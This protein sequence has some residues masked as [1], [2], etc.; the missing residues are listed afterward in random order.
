MNES[1]L[2]RIL[3]DHKRQTRSLALILYLSM[4]VSLGTF[5][6]FHKTAV[7]KVYTKKVLDCPCSY[8]GAKPVAHTHND[9]C[10]EGDTLV[11]KLTELEAHTHSD[12]CYTE[13]QVLS[14]GLEESPGHQH[15]DECYDADAA[16]ICTIP[17][18]EGAHTHTA[19]CY[20]TVRELICDKP[21]LPL[22]VHD[23]DCFYTE[24]ITIDETEQT[25]EPEQ[26]N[27]PKEEEQTLPEMP[28]GDPN[29]DLESAA[30]WERDFD[31][32]EL[33]GN[34][35]ADLILVAATQQGHGESSNNFKAV[36]N[37]AGDAWVKH[38]YTRYGAWYGN[39]YGEW[40]AMFVSFCLR[41]AGIPDK[42]IPNKSTAAAMGESFRNHELFAGRN[43]VPAVGDLIF[44]DTDDTEGIDLMGIVYYVDEENGTINTVE[45]DRTDEV[46]TFGYHLDD[47]EIAGYGILLQN[48]DYVYDETEEDETGVLIVTTEDKDENEEF[49]ATTKVKNEETNENEERQNTKKETMPAQSWERTAGGI[50]VVVEAPEGAFPENT[51]IAV[52]PVNGNSL[53]D[54]VSDAV[55]GEVLEVQAV[56]ITFFNAEGR[57]IEP[58]TAIRVTMIPAETENAEE[59]ANVVH[60]DVGQQTAELIAQAEGTETDNSE[61]VFDAEAFT[62]YAIVYTVHFEYEVDGETFTSASMPGAEYTSLAEVIRGLGIVSKEEI[63]TFVSRIATVA[64]TNEDVAK[65]ENT[66]EGL[67]VRVLKDG[68]AQIVITMQDG[69]AFRVDVVADGETAT[70]N[71]TATVSTVGDLYLPAEAKVEAKV[72]NETQSENAIA[73]VQAVEEP[74]D[75]N[76]AAETA[77][78]VFDISLENVEADQYDGFQVEVT[79]PDNVVGRD[80]RL[81]HIHDGETSEIELNTVSR[82]ADDTG[83]EV[84]SGFTFETKDFSEFVLRY[85]V[86]FTYEGR[87]WSFPGEGSYRLADILAVLG[88]EGSIDDASVTLIEGEDHAGALYLTQNDGEYYIN[89]DIAFTDIYELRVQIGEKIYIITVTDEQEREVSLRE[90]LQFVNIKIDGT[91]VVDDTWEVNEGQQY[92]ITL[93]FEET[94]S[95][96]QLNTSGE[97]S[98]QL[99]EGIIIP[100]TLNADLP[101]KHNG[102]PLR[103]NKFSVSTDGKITLELTEE[104]KQHI[105]DSGDSKF[106]INII[107]QFDGKTTVFEFNDDIIKEVEVTPKHNAKVEKTSTYDPQSGKIHY[108]V[109]VIAEGS[110][111]NVKVGDTVTGN[112]AQNISNF[113]VSKEATSQ[114][115]GNGAKSYELIFDTLTNEMVTIEYD[116]PID[117]SQFSGDIRTQTIGNN[118]EV[119]GDDDDNPN[120]NKTSTSNTISASSFNKRGTTEEEAFTGVDGKTYKR[121]KW[122]VEANDQRIMQL[123]FIEDHIAENSKDRMKYDWDKGIDVVVTKEDGTTSTIHLTKEEV[124]GTDYSWRF[125]TSSYGKASFKA[126]YYTIVEISGLVDDILVTNEAES[127]QGGSGSSVN[128]GPNEEDKLQ[129]EKKAIDVN[130]E[131]ITWKITINVPAD[132]YESLK[133]VEELPHSNGN[134]TYYD[135]LVVPDDNDWSSCVSGLLEGE[136]MELVESDSTQATFVFYKSAGETDENTGLNPT[137]DGKNR[138]V[139]ITLKTKNNKE[140]LEESITVKWRKDHEN[141]AKVTANN[142]EKTAKDTAYPP[143]KHIIKVTESSD[144]KTVNG[145]E[146]PRYHFTA[147]LEG[148]DQDSLTL[149]ET[150]DTSIFMIDDEKGVHIYAGNSAYWVG[151]NERTADSVQATYT[152]AV[153]T[154]NSLEKKDGKRFN[155]YK[156]DYYLVV[157]DEEALKNLYVKADAA[158]NHRETFQNTI[159]WGA[160]EGNS[161]FDYSYPSVTKSAALN[162]ETGIVY[163]T[164]VINPEKIKLLNGADEERIKLED[165]F[166]N[167]AVKF[168]TINIVSEPDRGQI[169]Y[170]YSG[171]TGTFWIPDETKVIITYQ[172][173]VV[174]DDHVSYYNKAVMKG[175]FSEQNGE[176]TADADGSG[177][178]NTYRI[179][180]FKYGKTNMATGLDGAEFTLVDQSG[181]PYRYPAGTEKAGQ[182]IKF[183]T[184][185]QTIDGEQ[186]HGYADIFLSEQGDGI[187]LRPGQRYYLKETKAPDGYKVADFLYS[188]TISPH[189]NYDNYEFYLDDVLKARDE[190]VE[191]SIVIR[192]S[193]SGTNTGLTDVQRKAITFTITKENDSSFAPV[194]LTYDQFIDDMYVL[195]GLKDGTYIVTETNNSIPGYTYNATTYTLDGG[196]VTPS[197][198]VSV[199]ISNADTHTVMITNEYANTDASIRIKK[200]DADNNSYSLYG[201]EFKLQKKNE[202]GNYED[203]ETEILENSIVRIDYKNMDT[204]VTLVGLEGGD[205][206]LVEIKAPDGYHGLEKPIRF[207]I[208]A[209]GVATDGVTYD[210][211]AVSGDPVSSEHLVSY[212]SNNKMLTVGNKIWHTYTIAK[213]QKGDSEKVLEGAKFTVYKVTNVGSQVQNGRIVADLDTL[214]VIKTY[215][216][217]ADGQLRICWEDNCYEEEQMYVVVETGAPAGY[218]LPELKDRPAYLFHF[219]GTG[220]GIDLKQKSGYAFVEDDLKTTVLA[221]AKSW[222]NLD[223]QDINSSAPVDQ[224]TFK[225]KQTVTVNGET[226]ENYYPDEET[227]YSVRKVNGNWTNTLINNLPKYFVEDGTEYAYIY[228]VEEQE[229]EGFVTRYSDPEDYLENNAVV[230]SKITITNE[231]ESVSISAKKVWAEG[232]PEEKKLAQN[233]SFELERR[234][235]TDTDAAWEKVPN[236]RKNITAWDGTGFAPVND[237]WKVE[238][239]RLS[240]EY[241]YRAVE[242]IQGANSDRFD[243]DYSKDEDGNIIVTNT[244]KST[245]ISAKKVW[246]DNTPDAKKSFDLKFQLQKKAKDA[247]E[248]VDFEDY[249]Q[250][251][252]ITTYSTDLHSYVPIVNGTKTENQKWIAT[253]NNWEA[254]WKDL[255]SEYIY[256]VKEILPV[257]QTDKFEIT[258]SENNKEGIERGEITVTNTYNKTFVEVEK[259][260]KDAETSHPAI[261]LELRRFSDTHPVEKHKEGYIPENQTHYTFSDLEVNDEEGNPWKYYVIESWFNNMGAYDISC[262]VTA[263]NAITSGKILITNTKKNEDE[264]AVKKLWLDKDG[265]PID[266]PDDNQSIDIQL[267][268]RQGVIKPGGVPVTL[269]VSNDLQY[270]IT[271]K[272]NSILVF[273][274]KNY[275]NGCDSNIE[276]F[277]FID[278]S[279]DSETNAS[280]DYYTYQIGTESVTVSFSGNSS[281]S[282]EFVSFEQDMEFGPAENVGSP[283]ELS[284]ANNWAYKWTDLTPAQN[285]IYFVEEITSVEGF[286]QE[287]ENN[288]G[289]RTGIIYVKNIKEENDTGALKFTKQ[290]TVNGNTPDH[291]TKQL[292]DGDYTFTITGP[293]TGAI[294]TINQ[295]VVIKVED[296]TAAQYKIDTEFVPLPPDGYV[297]ISDLPEGD[298]VI[299]ETEK[300]N[301]TLVSIERGDMKNDGTY[302]NGSPV[303]LADSRV[304]VHVTA[305]DIQAV[306]PDAKATFTNNLIEVS[307]LEGTKKWSITGTE[308]PTDPQLKLIRTANG[309]TTEVTVPEGQPVWTGENEN[310]TFKYTDLPKYNQQGY[311]YTYNVSEASFTIRRGDNEFHYRV[312]RDESG[313]YN[314]T[315][316]KQNAPKFTVTQTENAIINIEL[317]DFE[318]SKIWKNAS[319]GEA[320]WQ[321]N[322]AI[323]VTVSRK[324]EQSS[325]E[326][327]ETVGTYTILKTESGFTITKQTAQETTP[328]LVEMAG[329][330]EKTYTFQIQNLPKTGTIEGVTGEYT[331]SVTESALSGYN[332]RYETPDA[333]QP[334]KTITTPG[335]AGNGGWIINTPVGGYELPE[336]GGIGTTLFTALGGLMTVTAGAILTMRRGKRKIAEG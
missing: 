173:R 113:T 180:L 326:K 242:I 127:D 327:T 151:E 282:I 10:Y 44:F 4:L 36:L 224:V 136:H 313:A 221:V 122:E 287:Y 246:S 295:T 100:Y 304:T 207:T 139:V 185:E 208:G 274:I 152:G 89:S 212:E 8:E 177:I 172:A 203:Y 300:N 26:T 233:I 332:T 15:T 201:A 285:E 35:A 78:Q 324:T 171:N 291:D 148:I 196:A 289:I 312:T 90:L 88:I 47:E 335:Y 187:S 117:Y 118:V 63:D 28:V 273:R 102:I 75:S 314:V 52:T 165:S 50:K 278:D 331:Y 38:G 248:N 79:L 192:K 226:T 232:T 56:D 236:S 328:D 169:E 261:N 2:N 104:T 277:S 141:T 227:T 176:Y 158:D 316:D 160:I 71:E 84:V 258:Y 205:Y 199:T 318:F 186:K 211:A 237:E 83:L 222:R 298:Y 174:G 292:A 256:R 336:T 228:S 234:S 125:D 265:N 135:S 64:S 323:T 133:L 189:P 65:V 12:A 154:F 269:K 134:P 231:P 217:D 183:I 241:E 34:W 57:E 31:D 315:A 46:A 309:E 131:E 13:R 19:E 230:G 156:V 94:P 286:D 301:L 6:G 155:Y 311:Q 197:G 290:V 108:I 18:G 105:R 68:D 29:A 308:T 184:E 260:W 191:G 27:E 200:V 39:P 66:E 243:V 3:R 214:D 168:D 166:T 161:T 128:V 53:K 82:P 132:G 219:G 97:I 92:E 51:K 22:H 98:Y 325:A 143:V 280:W 14:C 276:P 202:S 238:W 288:D 129:V 43:F 263:E 103:G 175:Y 116:V 245:E 157:K 109:K 239:N 188:F 146:Y 24:E 16:L 61:V 69:A 220:A 268:R 266:P 235:K 223:N 162:Q 333:V 271:V 37:D 182:E 299:T 7:A 262:S 126:T 30:D 91:T 106:E 193:I 58:A 206:Q 49:I 306:R 77:Y 302:E 147:Q 247:G 40:S 317:T 293:G 209:A 195:S 120:D 59:K 138:T 130:S 252:D 254:I 45:G 112:A 142:I 121:V 198:P 297:T 179:K 194:N 1:L 307:S 25:T 319:L 244:Y 190:P 264:I 178:V 250:P 17:E 281:N 95:G 329:I 149:E 96:K 150:F 101:I 72:L 110:V 111:T 170:D 303:E 251:V 249:G 76:T 321:D 218:V 159:K 33:S 164:L 279:W 85:T 213:A 275:W 259:L 119:T 137:A 124:Q 270:S 55:S 60:I 320:D 215:T 48:P 255:S 80:F 140:W 23:A 74:A 99:P 107:G 115:G 86:D 216:T 240:A 257:D 11:C 283:I 294:V 70:G 144:K 67:C 73:A 87:T 145:V 153:F 93:N 5:A 42:Y 330:G 181:T 9:D 32:L 322:Q 54:T 210:N 284:A 167:L 267:K 225:I 310:R 272:S 163:Y 114:T 21:E 20:E 253:I 334:D 296:G 229:I 41:Y 81:Y 305:G 204:G 123:S 62:I